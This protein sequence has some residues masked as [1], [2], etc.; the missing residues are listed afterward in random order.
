[1]IYITQNAFTCVLNLKVYFEANTSNV[2]VF[3]KIP[4]ADII[5]WYAIVYN[6]SIE[7]EYI[8]FSM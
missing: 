7:I 5:N 8:Y 3:I 1:M 2:A 6:L 4:I